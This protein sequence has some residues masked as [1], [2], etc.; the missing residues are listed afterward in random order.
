MDKSE[1]ILSI[2]LD[3]DDAF[4]YLSAQD[5]AIFMSSCK[6]AYNSKVLQKMQTKHRAWYLFYKAWYVMEEA[7]LVLKHYRTI[8]DL[9][10]SRKLFAEHKQL[11]KSFEDETIDIKDC[12]SRVLIAEYKELLYH[13][14][15]DYIDNSSYYHCKHL[16]ESFKYNM[17]TNLSFC[18]IL[19]HIHDPTHYVF[20]NI[21]SNCY[22]FYHQI[23]RQGKS[24]LQ[25]AKCKKFIA[26]MEGTYDS[27][28]SD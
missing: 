27:D 18:N 6:N 2:V 24:A 4:H 1:L 9:D 21:D 17:L 3:N 12:L 26:I 28:D 7:H 13:L 25:D 22:K 10:L 11:V 15:Y 20:M 19:T 8:Q 5:I 23:E 16:Y 14:A